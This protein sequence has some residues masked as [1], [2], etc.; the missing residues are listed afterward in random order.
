M[1]ARDEHVNRGNG[2][3]RVL[4]IDPGLALTGYALLEME[5]DLCRVLDYGCIRTPAGQE[6]PQRLLTVFENVCALIGRF[7]PGTLALEQLF[8][9]KNVRT[10]TQVGEARG[11]VLTAAAV[12]NVPVVE[13]TPL[14]VKQA[15]TGYGKAEK[16]QI[17]QM[18]SLILRLPELPQPDDAADALAIALCH[19]QSRSWQKKVKCQK[20]KVKGLF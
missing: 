20:S 15:V 9:C 16:K 10:A 7:T 1:E 6:L 13:Y 17:Q 8:F 5:G 3:E 12:L 11:A 19:L 18:V 14:Q 4:G 2:A